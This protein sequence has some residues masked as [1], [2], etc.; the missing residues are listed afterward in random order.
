MHH[1]SIAV[2]QLS[3]RMDNLDFHR[4]LTIFV[5]EF[6]KDPKKYRC[7]L[8]Q[9]LYLKYLK[10]NLMNSPNR[11]DFAR[12]LVFQGLYPSDWYIYK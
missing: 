11:Y 7:L 9:F 5:F 1:D 8:F 4:R 2:Y 3:Y 10:I 12:Q 6:A